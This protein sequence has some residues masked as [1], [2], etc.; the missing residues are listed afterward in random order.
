MK[1]TLTLL[2]LFTPGLFFT[3]FSQTWSNFQ[4]FGG[5]GTEICSGL[6]ID[7]NGSAVLSGSFNNQIAFGNQTLNAIGEEDI[8]VCKLK[9]NG[10][11]AWAKRAGSRLEDGV[12]DIALDA[13]NNLVVT[14]TYWGSGDFDAIQLTAGT[15]PKAIFLTKYNSDGQVLWAKS[16]NGSGLK[17]TQAIA[18]DS[19]NNILL[20]G[21]FEDSLQIAD[22]ILI[23]K[24]L[25]DLF[26]AKFSSEGGLLWA[27][28]QG[29]KGNTRGTA[30]GL[31]RNGDPI[32]AGFFDDS[33]R[34]A[35]TI[36]TANTLDQDAF[37]ARFSK[38]GIPIW[39]KK[40]GGVFDSDVTALLLDAQDHIYMSGYFVGT[41]RLSPQM[42]ITSSSGNADIFLLKYKSD[43]TP[44]S[45]R[46]LG[47][48]MLEQALDMTIQNNIL[49]VS[50]FYQGNLKLDQFSC[51]QAIR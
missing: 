34:I 37:V 5:A 46:A 36:L 12:A 33:T 9:P 32:V 29:Y 20:T 23:S 3:A 40:A 43:G 19:Q 13:A 38:D 27:V 16:L 35:D 14:G 44:L 22:T 7:K 15:N 4:T 42:S 17:G 1:Q 49:L 6:A 11:V 28:R 30:L 45:A 31:M 18:C 50:G 48:T 41:M 25:T 51:Q 26:L 39:A 10:E 24:G 21:Y 2:V 47:G 8:F